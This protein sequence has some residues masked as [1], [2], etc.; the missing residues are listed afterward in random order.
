MLSMTSGT[1]GTSRE[2]QGPLARES[3]LRGPGL[4]GHMPDMLGRFS[5]GHLD[6]R[7]RS[8]R[9]GLI[10]LDMLEDFVDG[11]LGGLSHFGPDWLT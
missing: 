1:R 7:E 11:V 4:R 5:T 3:G 9:T 2:H 10:V 6:R 8:M